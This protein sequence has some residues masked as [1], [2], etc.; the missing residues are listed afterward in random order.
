MA[1]QQLSGNA[2]RSALQRGVDAV[3]NAVKQT[4]GPRGRNVLI[5]RPGQ[6]VATRDG[7]TVAKETAN[8]PDR[9]ENMGASYA[10][11]T[12][13]AAVTEAGDGTTTATVIL[14][15]I[16]TGGLDLVSNGVEPLL[17]AD[18]IE[19]AATAIAATIKSLAVA[20]T[21]ELVR[22][23][24]IISTHGDIELGTMIA[25]ATCKVGATGV[26]E[27]QESRDETTTIEH[28]TGFYFER[29]FGQIQWF[30]NDK[31]GRKC[32]LKNP[33]ILISERQIIGSGIAPNGQKIKGDG[34]F[35]V[36]EIASKER[37]PLLIIAE[38]LIGDALA[39]LAAN[40]AKGTVDF[41]FVKLP[42]FGDQR[43]AAIED[44]R[45]AIGAKRIHTQTSTRQDDQL[46][47]F[48]LE[49]LGW[50][51]NAIITSTRTVLIGGGANEMLKTKR[52]KQLIDQSQE[53]GNPF[54]KE[55]LDHRIAR[56]TGGVAVLRV[57]AHSEPAMIE[58]KARAE[59]AIHA[60]RGALA[61]GLVS[62]AGMALVRA[63]KT[64]ADTFKYDHDSGEGLLLRAITEPARQILRNSGKKEASV[65]A[66]I[67]GLSVDAGQND[68]Y[69]SATNKVGDLFEMGIVDPAK[70]VITALTKAASIG[71]LLLT[72]EVLVTDI[73]EPMPQVQMP[74]AMRMG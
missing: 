60:C 31:S 47:D 27:L 32:E 55:Q 73:P 28:L 62:G 46:S 10:K 42:G 5:D 67:D 7:V 14:Q 19:H 25:E 58:K 43:T 16:V 66:I 1:K 11:E 21:P 30:A 2:A 54:E 36:A 69:N 38:D 59:D 49:D 35:S 39:F 18:G 68:G 57:G 26:L 29:G 71:A 63:A 34:I 33:L 53:S 72:T 22:Q 51:E 44:L 8:L 61:E 74:P 65:E 9:F 41:A 23:A 40:K 64:Y 15:A 13:D 52:V 24:A 48:T 37:R 20:A 70:V 45:I 17:L 3:A 50:C 56:L 12:A 6:P 4:L